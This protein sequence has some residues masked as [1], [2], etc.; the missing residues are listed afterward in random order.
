MN[1]NTTEDTMMNLDEDVTTSDT[2]RMNAVRLAHE[3]KIVG[4]AAVENEFVYRVVSSS[5]AD[6]HYVF[7]DP[8][9][10]AVVCDCPNGQYRRPCSHAGAV[11]LLVARLAPARRRNP[12]GRVE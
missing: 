3:K 12:A 7:Y 8:A 10:Q 6:D 11:L 1:R 5:E 2:W 4:Q 9:S